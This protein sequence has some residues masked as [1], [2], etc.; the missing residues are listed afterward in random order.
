MAI[1]DDQPKDCDPNPEP[2]EWQDMDDYPVEF[3]L[4]CYCHA[5]EAVTS[6]NLCGVCDAIANQLPFAGNQ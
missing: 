1:L 6:T 4:C 3:E 5:A 2:D